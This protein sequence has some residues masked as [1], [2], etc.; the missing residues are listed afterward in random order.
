MKIFVRPP[1][2]KKKDDTELEINADELIE[3]VRKR[4]GEK[5]GMDCH[6]LIHRGAN[7]K[8]EQTLRSGDVPDGAI[9]IVQGAYYGQYLPMGVTPQMEKRKA[10]EAGLDDLIE[11]APEAKR[12][13]AETAAEN[14]SETTVAWANARAAVYGEK[15]MR[16][17]MEDEHLLCPS[18][19]VQCK[20]L[21][22]ERDFA[23]F[24]IFDGHGGKQVAGFVKTYLPVELGNAFAADEPR[25]GPLSDKRLKKVIETVFQ[26][27]DTRIATELSGCYDGSTAVVLMVNAEVSVCV[28]LGDS[29]A[30]LCRFADD[31]MQAIPLQ[32]RQ[33]K[34]WMM[35]E[36]ERILRSGGAV[37]NGRI[38]GVLEVSRAFGDM[39]LKKFGVLVTPEYMK[40]KVDLE[41]DRFVVLACD[42][43]WNAWTASEALEFTNDV[44]EAEVERARGEGEK[45]DLKSCCRE[46][47]QHVVQEKKAQDNVSALIVQFTAPA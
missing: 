20:S 8:D 10:E 23:V 26:R 44:I 11:L 2:G 4:I 42:G 47:V 14:L 5:T 6:K 41:K 19:R 1:D 30:Y 46:L 31:D 28:H 35:K 34:C 22:E 29:M 7:L 36:K 16:R 17:Q 33:H 27:L 9:L 12:V 24:A 40:F 21:P 25:E 3:S 37:E 18:L 43:F 38:N 45:P 13:A 39:T 32:M 15:G